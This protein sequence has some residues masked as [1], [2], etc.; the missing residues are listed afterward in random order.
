M[1]ILIMD[2]HKS[3]LYFTLSPVGLAQ[4][5]AGFGLRLT[6]KSLLLHTILV[7]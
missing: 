3:K 4:A 5:W 6:K 1:K 2:L 7:D